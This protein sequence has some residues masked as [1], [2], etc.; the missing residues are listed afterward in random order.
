MITRPYLLSTTSSRSSIGG[1][2]MPSAGGVAAK[3]CLP[4]LDSVRSLPCKVVPG[5]AVSGAAI[6]GQHQGYQLVANIFDR[7]VDQRDVELVAGGQLTPRGLEPAAD[8][9]RRLGVPADQ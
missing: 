6:L 7:C 3:V 9:L 8:G 1:L 4:D 2:M 5:V